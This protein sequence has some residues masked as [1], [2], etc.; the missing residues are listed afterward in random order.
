MLSG[1]TIVLILKI[2]KYIADKND[3][4]RRR[5]IS[6]VTVGTKEKQIRGFVTKDYG[7]II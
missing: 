7:N 6:G 5:L 2:I 4:L 3:E 1:C